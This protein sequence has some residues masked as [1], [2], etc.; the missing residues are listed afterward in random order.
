M[1][2]LLDTSICV[3]FCV[4][5]IKLGVMPSEPNRNKEIHEI[6]KTRKN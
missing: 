2:Y 4:E 1:Q 6:R 5:K 3:F